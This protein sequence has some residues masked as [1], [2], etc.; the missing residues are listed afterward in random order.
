MI[1]LPP[2]SSSFLHNLRTKKKKLP[3]TLRKSLHSKLILLSFSQINS[4]F[5]FQFSIV[6]HFFFFF[7]FFFFFPSHARSK[8]DDEAINSATS[9]NYTSSFLLLSLLTAAAA[10]ITSTTTTTTRILHR[11]IRKVSSCPATHFSDF[12]LVPQIL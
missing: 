3:R 5:S 9:R 8:P 4:T 7:F 1:S 11:I 12:L 10:A 2:P 6:H